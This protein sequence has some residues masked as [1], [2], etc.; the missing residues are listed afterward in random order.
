MEL[1]LRQVAPD[2]FEQWIRAEPRAH[3]SQLVGDPAEH[4]P[5]YDLDRSIAV[6]DRGNIVGGAYSYRFEMSVPGG[7]AITAGVSD[8]TVQPTHRRR[9]ILTRM[10]DY[11]LKDVHERGEPLAALFASES[12]IYGRFGYGIGSFQERWKIDR[13]YNGYA[14][15]YE[16]QGRISFV[17]PADI[18]KIFPDVFRRSTIDTPGVVQRPG[19]RWDEIARDPEHWRRGASAFFHAIYEENRSV[20][21]YVGYR[22]KGDTLTVHE[23]MAVTN[24]ARAGL[25]R[26]CF[27]VDLTRS[28]EALIRPVDDP[29]PWMLADPRR[30]ERSPGDGMWLRL[31]DVRA[32]LAAR[33]Y[34]QSERL[35]ID[36]RDKFCPWNEG[37]FELEGDPEGA[38]CRASTSSPDLVLSAADLA[39]AYLGTVRFTTLSRAG[40]VEERTPTALQRADAMFS[41]LHQPWTPIN[42]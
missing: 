26:F 17:E 37:R 20:D 39:A 35:V 28:T 40:R 23:L 16:Q 38:E 3:G 9:G 27:D 33:R 31:V 24:E 8:V 2:E 7:S 13:Q 32:A 12:V 42:W 10:M 5:F 1:E 41:S 22:V 29:L 21:G 14:R 25:W 4:R 19:Q 6:F 11:Q 36:V 15:P 34:T 30:L 18:V